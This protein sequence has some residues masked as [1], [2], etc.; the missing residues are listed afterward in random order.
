VDPGGAQLSA[1]ALEQR[2]EQLY[3][4]GWGY[5]CEAAKAATRLPT[6]HP[7]AFI[8]A[9]A[10]VYKNFTDSLRCR[11]LGVKPTAIQADYPTVVDGA[12]GVFFINKAVESSAS[13]V[14]WFPA[15]FTL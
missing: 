15:A 12:R 3:K 9:F 14:K 8:E 2:P 7:E 10:N 11:I 6:G 13:D 4:R 5:N 1:G